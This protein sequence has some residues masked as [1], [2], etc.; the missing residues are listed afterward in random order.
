MLSISNV[1]EDIAT[2]ITLTTVLG[3]NLTFEKNEVVVN[4]QVKE[5]TQKSLLIPLTLKNL[6]TPLK[7][8][9][10]PENIAV[11]FEVSVENFNKIDE[12]DF[13]IEIDYDRK[14]EVENYMIPQLIKFPETVLN[15]ELRQEK[16][17]YLILK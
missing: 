13:L 10:L 3:E 12:S 2:T 6:P 14:N 5:F 1:A 15:I 7:I 9:L 8:K 11:V 16:V 17:N 4:C